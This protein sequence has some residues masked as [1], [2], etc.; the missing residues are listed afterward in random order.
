MEYLWA[1]PLG[2]PNPPGQVQASGRSASCP[3][4]SP[5]LPQVAL[6]P[7]WTIWHLPECRSCQAWPT[8]PINMVR[9]GWRIKT[10]Q[11]HGRKEQ[12]GAANHDSN[13]R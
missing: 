1:Q 3:Q 9:S 8:T 11:A 12:P 10:T 2:A 13:N 5:S 6:V 4:L 7:T